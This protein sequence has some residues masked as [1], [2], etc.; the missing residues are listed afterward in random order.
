MLRGVLIDLSGTLH[1]DNAVTPHSVEAL[2]RL[3]KAGIKVLFCSNTTKE[4]GSQLHARLT[5]LGFQHHPK[6]LFTSLMAA[7]QLV[8]KYHLNPLL[9]LSPSANSD[10][11]KLVNTDA[12]PNAVVVGL[13]PEDFNYLKLN[14]AFNLIR[15]G[16]PL[17]A[18]HKARYYA[19]PAGLAM[20]PGGFV[21]ALEYATRTQA[22]VVGKPEKTFFTLALEALGLE[23]CPHEVAM[24]GDDV[25]HD[26]G[27]G[28]VTLGLQRYLVKTGKY[29]PGDETRVDPP[30]DGVFDNFATVVD[31]I[32][33]KHV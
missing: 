14:E 6:E 32:L 19:T 16:A 27:G 3:R 29:L 20:G 31:A 7:L 8:K 30:P 23:D 11:T 26:L 4:G 13:S 21:E 1:I 18:I 12:K 28:A 17:I 9:F 10:F 5:N 33:S 25:E 24:I 22:T 2:Q 15:K